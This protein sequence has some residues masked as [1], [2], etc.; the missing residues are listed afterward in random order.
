LG[1]LDEC[2]W[3]RISEP[4]QHAWSEPDHPLR[5]KSK[6]LADGE[7]KAL[8]CYGIWLPHSEEML[9]RFV[10]GRPV[11]AVTTAFLDWLSAVRYAAGKRVLF[12]VWDNAAWH[13]SAAVRA[14][15]KEH[16]RLV[17]AGK[18]EGVRLVVC[19]L[20]VKSPWLNPIEPKW[21]HGKRA[22]G[23]P[24]GVLD[25]IELMT[26]ILMHFNCPAYPLLSTTVT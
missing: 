17:R 12:L 23:E 3:S 14:W 19:Q 22:V 21:L 7:R 26:R 1:F 20:P 2:W 10:D 24:G 8:A 11:S 6:A 25:E 16:N 15:I 9:L 4:A 5:L 18:K 13:V